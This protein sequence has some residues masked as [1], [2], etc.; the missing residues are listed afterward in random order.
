LEK[1]NHISPNISNIYPFYW[2]W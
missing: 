1:T 2:I